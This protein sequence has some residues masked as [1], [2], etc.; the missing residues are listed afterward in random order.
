MNREGFA[1]TSTSEASGSDKAIYVALGARAGYGALRHSG[2]CNARSADAL[3]TASRTARVVGFS[4]LGH[5]EALAIMA[6]QDAFPCPP[7]ASWPQK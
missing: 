4:E 3:A 1:G 2:S 7:A 6:L 5:G